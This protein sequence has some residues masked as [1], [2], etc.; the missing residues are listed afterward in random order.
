MILERISELNPKA[1]KA[2]GFD[3]AI[4]GISTRI[5]DDNLIAYDYDKYFKVLSCLR[6]A[7]IDGELSEENPCFKLILLKL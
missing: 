1:L 6:K 3:D 7:L 4:L 2:D 5:G